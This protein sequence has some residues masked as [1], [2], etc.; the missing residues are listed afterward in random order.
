MALDTGFE[1]ST[2]KVTKLP[3]SEVVIKRNEELAKNQ[4]FTVLKFANRRGNQYW[5]H[6]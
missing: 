3:L 6:L 4:G 5:M 1:L 2:Q